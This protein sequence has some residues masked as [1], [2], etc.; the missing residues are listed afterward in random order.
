MPDGAA[1]ATDVASRGLYRFT[2]A[3]YQ[4]LPEIGVLDEDARVELIEGVI[5]PMSPAGVAHHF[6]VY[7]L[8]DLLSAALE[9]RFKVRAENAV[10]FGEHSQPVPDISVIRR[11]PDIYRHR[12]PGPSDILLLAEAADSSLA[13]DRRDKLPLYA[14]HGIAEF[15]LISLAERHAEVFRDPADGAFRSAG[16]VELDG[17]LTPLVGPDLR[18]PLRA[19]LSDGDAGA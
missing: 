17:F 11:R 15:W 18:I 12:L 2:A 16:T 5:V 9:P 1:L 14:M 8:Q 19:L 13:R 7:M 3:E 4:R 10:Q 6:A